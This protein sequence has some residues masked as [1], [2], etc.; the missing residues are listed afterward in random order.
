LVLGEQLTWQ[1]L[2]GAVLIIAGSLVLALA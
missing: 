2:L 1:V